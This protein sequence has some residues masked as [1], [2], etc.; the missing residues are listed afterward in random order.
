MIKDP[1]TD[2]SPPPETIRKITSQIQEKVNS[3]WEMPLGWLFKGLTITMPQRDET[4]G[5]AQQLRLRLA[6]NTAS[7]AGATL[8]SSSLSSPSKDPQV[9]HIVVDTHSTASEISSIRASLSARAS[10]K[11]PHLVTVE[12]IEESWKQRA[13]LDEERTLFHFPYFPFW[14]LSKINHPLNL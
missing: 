5:P 12:W 2:N 9:T 1:N 11:M 4:D 6:S 14:I 7:F 3:G 13:L 10:G 8:A